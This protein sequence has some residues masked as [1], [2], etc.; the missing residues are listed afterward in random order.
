METLQYV[1]ALGQAETDDVICNTL[2]C[3]LGVLAD[4]IGRVQNY[5]NK[6]IE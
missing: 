5:E 1:F 6:V 4:W 3:G 2:G